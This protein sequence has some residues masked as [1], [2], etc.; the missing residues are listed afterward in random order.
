VLSLTDDAEEIKKLKYPLQEAVYL[1]AGKRCS[2][3]ITKPGKLAT[4]LRQFVGTSEQ[5]LGGQR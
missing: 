2:A 1:C 5:R 4:E 3:P